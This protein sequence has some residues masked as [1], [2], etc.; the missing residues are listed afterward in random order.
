[1]QRD[2][3]KSHAVLIFMIMKNDYL[4]N[5]DKLRTM[6]WKDQVLTLAANGAEER[7][8]RALIRTHPD[9]EWDTL[10]E[11]DTPMVIFDAIQ[12]LYWEKDAFASH[13]EIKEQPK[14]RP[15]TELLEDFNGVGKKQLARK[16][17]QIRLPY[18]TADEQKRVIYTFLDTSAKTDRVFVLKYLDKHFELMYLEAVKVVWELYHDFEAAKVLTHY[19]PDEFIIANFE[20]LVDDYRYLPVRLR[21]PSSTP[22]DH[23]KLEMHEFLY[24]CARQHLPIAAEEAFA[25]LSNTI[26]QQL[27]RE[28]FNYKDPSLYKLTFISSI[29]W[30]LGELGFEDIIL[31]FY[32]ENER[33]KPLFT[34]DNRDKVLSKLQEQLNKDGFAVT[35]NIL[36]TKTL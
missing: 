11:D 20:Q 1:M 33:T 15:V 27:E 32:L 21:M 26:H 18:L 24:L 31:R 4:I 19:A 29:L 10:N 3:Q 6:S 34:S 12:T 5:E 8:I 25:V 30:S 9:E 16:E 28:S 7:I 14:Y 23:S 36:H 35:P 22:I 2:S 17:L 13:H